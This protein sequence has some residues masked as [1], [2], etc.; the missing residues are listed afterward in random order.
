MKTRSR[1]VLEM[2]RNPSQIFK[3]AYLLIPAF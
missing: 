2:G 1:L 3:D